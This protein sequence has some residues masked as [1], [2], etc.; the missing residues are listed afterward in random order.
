[1]NRTMVTAA[2]TLPAAVLAVFGQFS[3]QQEPNEAP[4]AQAVAT[5]HSAFRAL[6]TDIDCG[7]HWGD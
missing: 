7:K 3:S 4:P 6:T 1:M 2:L 5:Q